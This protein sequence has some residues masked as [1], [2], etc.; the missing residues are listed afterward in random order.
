MRVLVAFL[1]LCMSSAI[2][3]ALV[4]PVSNS[5]N[6]LSGIIPPGTLRPRASFSSPSWLSMQAA[7]GEME[8]GSGE[9]ELSVED[10]AAV[11]AAP[12]EDPEV[13]ALKEEISKLEAELKS[14]KSSLSY[15]VEQVEEYSKSGYARQVAEMENMRRVRSVM[16]SS[17]KSSAMAGVL[18]DF[19]PVYEKMESLKAKYQ[20]SLF[21][22][23]YSGLSI[24]PT[25]AKMGVKE[26]SVAE[27]EPVDL[28]RMKIVGSEVSAVAKNTVIRQVKPGL[29]LEG[30]VVQ[31]AEC[32]SS[33]GD[34]EN[35]DATPSDEAEVNSSSPGERS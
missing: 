29:E 13:V 19:V 12:E 9:Q 11:K 14:K 25:F 6:G 27:G 20:D 28:I 4:S 16:N 10:V 18:R 1:A 23:K 7:D 15:V 17:S 31:P 32:V 22:S 2:S 30:N 5:K 3:L 35:S 21:G 8:N 24:G 26:F 33:L 34:E